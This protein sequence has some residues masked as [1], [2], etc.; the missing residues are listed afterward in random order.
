M[1]RDHVL[2][3]GGTG[4][5]GGHVV[6]SLIELHPEYKIS[7][8]DLPAAGTWTPPRK[9]IAY[10]QG[11][12]RDFRDVTRAVQEARPTA[13]IHLAGV[14]PTGNDRYSQNQR[15]KDWVFK[16]NVEGTQNML[17]AARDGGVKAFVLTASITMVTDD[18]GTDYPNFD[19]TV[20]PTP[21]LIYGQSKVSL[22]NVLDTSIT[23]Y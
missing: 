23:P 1:A 10:Y 18:N 9:D 6:N 15:L 8:F 17:D 4:F 5:V 20:V 12:I 7:V 2:V 11:D 14:V 13:V 3:T 16:I 21:T 22:V 19:E